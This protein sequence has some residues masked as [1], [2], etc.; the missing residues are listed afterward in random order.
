MIG[1]YTLIKQSM[2]FVRKFNDTVIIHMRIIVQIFFKIIIKAMTIV[3][4]AKMT[5]CGGPCII[6]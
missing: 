6:I 4:I 5:S 3:I 2:T 1:E